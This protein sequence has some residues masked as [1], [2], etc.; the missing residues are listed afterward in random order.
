MKYPSQENSTQ[1]RVEKSV[2]KKLEKIQKKNNLHSIN[3]AVKLTLANHSLRSDIA[4]D[5][6]E[7]ATGY[8]IKK[9]LDKL[10]IR[11]N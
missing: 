10:T 6:F 8:N 4:P 3:E 1:I 5:Y 7:Q 2:K 9:E 11:P